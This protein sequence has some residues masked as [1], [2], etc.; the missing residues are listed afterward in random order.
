MACPPAGT[1]LAGILAVLLAG[2]LDMKATLAGKQHYLLY[3]LTPAMKP[4]MLMTGRL[5]LADPL[6]LARSFVLFSSL[7]ARTTAPLAAMA[8][9]PAPITAMCLPVR[10]ACQLLFL[11]SGSAAW[12]HVMPVHVLLHAEGPERFG[13][14]ERVPYP[15][16]AGMPLLDLISNRL[17]RRARA[18]RRHALTSRRPRA[19][20]GSSNMLRPGSEPQGSALLL[21]ISRAPY[22]HLPRT[23]TLSHTT[24]PHTPP[25]T[26]TM[27]PACTHGCTQL[28][29]QLAQA[30]RG[31]QSPTPLSPQGLHRLAA[32]SRADPAAGPS[33]PCPLRSGR[34]WP[35][36][37][38]PGA[39]G[40]GGGHC[41]AGG[42]AK[43]HHR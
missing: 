14:A 12:L 32:S 2:G 29:A 42:P 8:P 19:Q 21:L 35:D 20:P 6:L 9:V 13:A 36:A 24:P 30:W 38:V 1:A 18:Q 39:G 11:L 23:H 27:G 5:P 31:L 33:R 3:C 41:R 15:P 26:L 16:E 40:H 25:H 22:P 7:H 4:R 28:L 17:C 43:D 34:G 10:S 37:A